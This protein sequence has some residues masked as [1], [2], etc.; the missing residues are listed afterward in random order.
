MD[1]GII[2]ALITAVGGIFTQFV[3]ASN[4]KKSTTEIINFRVGALEQKVDK[5]NSV[6]DRTIKLETQMCEVQS[7]IQE[8]K[9][10]VDKIKIS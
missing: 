6:V 2:I 9:A 4:S 1:A 5:H 7:D 8:I 3:I 10:T